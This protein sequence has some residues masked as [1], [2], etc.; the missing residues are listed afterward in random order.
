MALHQDLV[1]LLK[2]KEQKLKALLVKVEVE[3][4]V[5]M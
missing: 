2:V 3:L 4:I 1:V 5:S